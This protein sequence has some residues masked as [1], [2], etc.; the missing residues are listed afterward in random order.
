[1]INISAVP[2]GVKN[3]K[4]WTEQIEHKTL[5]NRATSR[6]TRVLHYTTMMM[7]III[8]IRIDGGSV[9]SAVSCKMLVGCRLLGENTQGI[10]VE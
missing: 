7:T 2:R 8:I 9:V 10:L 4:L 3:T 1:M 5:N 6:N